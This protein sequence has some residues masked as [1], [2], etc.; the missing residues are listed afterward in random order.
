MVR[1]EPQYLGKG[2]AHLHPFV[3]VISQKKKNILNFSTHFMKH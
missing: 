1:E 3:V 2:F